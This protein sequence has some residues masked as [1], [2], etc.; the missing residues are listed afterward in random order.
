M[1]H[2]ALMIIEELRLALKSTFIQLSPT[3][4]LSWPQLCAGVSISFSVGLLAIFWIMLLNTGLFFHSW[5]EK[6]LGTLVGITYW[7]LVYVNK[8]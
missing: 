5:I 4:P 8:E 7:A 1:V 3:Q 6:G 2:S